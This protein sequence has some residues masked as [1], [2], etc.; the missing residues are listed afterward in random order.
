MRDQ[1]NTVELSTNATVAAG[2]ALVA[3]AAIGGGGLIAS[4]DGAQI[5]YYVSD[6]HAGWTGLAAQS[7]GVIGGGSGLVIG[8]IAGGASGAGILYG[9]AVG[10]VVGAVVGAGVGAA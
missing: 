8:G 6:G 1:R 7:Y 10:G 2:L 4:L 9:A 5:G 3:V